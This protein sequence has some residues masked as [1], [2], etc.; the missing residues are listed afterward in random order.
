MFHA[1]KK[2]SIKWRAKAA[3]KK[4]YVENFLKLVTTWIFLFVLYAPKNSTFID[5]RNEKE[6]M[7]PGY[8][9]GA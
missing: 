8:N 2:P 5:R 7:G 1:S 9:K 4:E 3:K 6:D